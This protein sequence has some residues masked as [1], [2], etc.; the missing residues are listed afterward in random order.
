MIESGDDALAREIAS[1]ENN[2][3]VAQIEHPG[4]PDWL[5]RNG[6]AAWE[7]AWIQPSYGPCGFGELP[8]VCGTDG[9]TYLCESVA[10]E[11]AGVEVAH[12]GAC[13]TDTEGGST[14]TGGTGPVI[15]EEVCVAMG[16]STGDTNTTGG[17]MSTSSGPDT[18][19]GSTAGDSDGTAGPIDATGGTP[20]GGDG[21]SGTEERAD[22]DDKGC[23]CRAGGT[24]SPTAVALGLLGLW[25][26]R[27]RRHG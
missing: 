9:N 13:G 21:S 14:D 26:L 16:S 6:F 25:G 1:Y 7:A 20:T 19:G 11:C 27:R 23:S 3:F 2:D 5:E 24:T 18:S 8:L 17:N 4:V 10:V 12:E 22:E 15:G